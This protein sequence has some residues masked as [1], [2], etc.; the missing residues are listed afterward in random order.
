MQ[1]QLVC[2][3]CR[4]IL[5][6]PRGATNVCCALCTTITQSPP[7]GLIVCQLE[8]DGN[9]LT[10]MWR[11]SNIANVHTWSNKYGEVFTSRKQ[12]YWVNCSRDYAIYFNKPI[13]CS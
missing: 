5:L 10:H 1:S 9:G 3:G 7:P 8:W 6:Y 11:L 13:S 2:S 12:T 4:S